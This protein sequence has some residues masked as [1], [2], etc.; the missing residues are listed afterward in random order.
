M[1]KKMGGAISLILA[2]LG[3]VIGLWATSGGKAVG[4]YILE[5]GTPTCSDPKWLLHNAM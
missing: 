1:G 3:I 4:S 2:L 5:S